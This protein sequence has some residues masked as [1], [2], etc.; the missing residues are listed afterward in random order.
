MIETSLEDVDTEFN[1]DKKILAKLSKLMNNYSASD[2]KA[3]IYQA[4]MKPLK[5]L[6]PEKLLEIEKSDIRQVT[7]EDFEQAVE[8]FIPSYSGATSLKEFTDWGKANKE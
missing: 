8:E 4:S 6:P 7:I 3:L 1:G 2:I 5:E